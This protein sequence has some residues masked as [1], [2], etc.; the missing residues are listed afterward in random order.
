MIVDKSRLKRD[1]HYSGCK[2][3]LIRILGTVYECTADVRAG[4]IFRT[5]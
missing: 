3:I 5:E 2:K 4:D 1:I